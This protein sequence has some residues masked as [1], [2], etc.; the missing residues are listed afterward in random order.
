MPAAAA[1]IWSSY[2]ALAN[3]SLIRAFA[4]LQSVALV[5]AACVASWLAVKAVAS[6]AAWVRTSVILNRSGIPRGP[7]FF[8]AYKRCT[9]KRVHRFLAH[10]MDMYGSLF[11]YRLGHLYVSRQA[12]AL[13]N[14]P[15]SSDPPDQHHSD[16]IFILLFGQFS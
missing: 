5:L 11:W 7:S 8:E 16:L 6:V 2:V 4:M 3:P 1:M 14:G 9:S 12:H 15:A 10:W 13:T